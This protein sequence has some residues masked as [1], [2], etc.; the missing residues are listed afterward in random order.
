MK[1]NKLKRRR[2]K[3]LSKRTKRLTGT[4]A[5]EAEE[6]ASKNK[7]RSQEIL[8]PTSTTSMPLTTGLSLA[9]TLRMVFLFYRLI[10]TLGLPCPLSG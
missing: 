7:R 2:R 9:N 5:E 4:H 6:E 3:Q 8:I 10:P 1:A